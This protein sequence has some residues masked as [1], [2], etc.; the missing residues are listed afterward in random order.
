MHG[1][2]MYALFVPGI[3]PNRNPRVG[4]AGTVRHQKYQS[5]DSSPKMVSR[6]QNQP[7]GQGQETKTG[8]DDTGRPFLHPWGTTC[9][10]V[11]AH[12]VPKT[13]TPSAI[14]MVGALTVVGAQSEPHRVPVSIAIPRSAITGPETRQSGPMRIVEALMRLPSTCT[15]ASSAMCSWLLTLPCTRAPAP[16]RSLPL[17]T[18]FTETIS[19]GWIS[20][21]S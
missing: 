11:R 19:P 2:Y 12:I 9:P 18:M 20:K 14:S 15:P 3:E 6:T 13:V 7:C 5:I 16:M 8:Y 1:N 17:V 21:S 10:S 4:K